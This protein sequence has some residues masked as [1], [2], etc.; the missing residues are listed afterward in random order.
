ME[1]RIKEL[2]SKN[3]DTSSLESQLEQVKL[4]RANDTSID[5]YNSSLKDYNSQLEKLDKEHD[6]ITTGQLDIDGKMVDRSY[7]TE[8]EFV[9]KYGGFTDALTKAQADFRYTNPEYKDAQKTHK[10]YM[11]KISVEQYVTSEE[12]LKA[13]AVREIAEKNLQSKSSNKGGS[14]GSNSNSDDKK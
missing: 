4:Q 9:K 13:I 14:S 2:S 6:Y 5:T 3:M 7:K 11:N 8:E 12:G 1:N 10:D